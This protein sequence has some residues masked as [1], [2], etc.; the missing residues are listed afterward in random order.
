MPPSVAIAVSGLGRIRRGS[1]TW[2]MDLAKALHDHGDAVRLHGS[3]RVEAAV[4]QSPAWSI[5][6]NSLWIRWLD[7]RRRYLVE[8]RTFAASLVR[9]LRRDLPDIVHVTDPQVSWWVRQA[10]RHQ[11]PRV[12]Y[13]DGL[14]LG[15]DWNWR[16]DHV[17]VLAPHYIETARDGGRDTAAWRVIPHFIDPAP[18]AADASRREDRARYLPGVP[19]DK[20][21]VLAVGDFAPGSAKR[22][23]HV[24]AEVAGIP[25]ADR[26]HLMLVGNA[27]P[28]ERR[29]MDGLAGR[30]LGDG[31]TILCS[32]GRA[33]MAAVYHCADLF[34]HAALKEPFGIV[35][36]EAM[37]SRLPVV[38][39]TFPVTRW[40]VGDG[41]R[42]VDMEET[43]A[44]GRALLDWIRDPDGRRQ[45]GD[46]A[47]ERVRQCY[48][49]VAVLP[50]YRR[51]YHEIH[52]DRARPAARP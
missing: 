22:L 52:A 32:L 28:A 5:G 44:L 20:P 49:D 42:C 12:F 15:P 31:V 51:A 13:M 40:I 48:S 26:P 25:A 34:A 2:A 35:L 45:A 50:L 10:F 17:Q 36:L 14:M 29:A 43:G 1:E 6:R 7:P 16:F 38:G 11:G 41:G 9:R 30:Q 23:D 37:A 3:A 19:A 27:T 18:F 39:H 21:V 33:E 47:R 46:R 8:Q 24:V 4:P